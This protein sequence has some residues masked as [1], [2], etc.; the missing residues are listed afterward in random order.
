MWLWRDSVGNS[1]P[2]YCFYKFL[3]ALG[4]FLMNR[5]FVGTLVVASLLAT[6]AMAA[7]LPVKA[8]YTKAP[9]IPVYNWTGFY[10]GVNVGGSWG[11]ES[12]DGY[13]TGSSS[14]QRYTSI[15]GV[16]VGAPVVTALPTLPITGRSNVNGVLGGGQAGYNW[17]WQS[18]VLGVEA[19]FQ[20]TDEHSTSALCTVSGCPTGTTLYSTEYKLDWFGTARG[21]AGFLVMPQLLLY[22]TGGLAYGH[23]SADGPGLAD[24]GNTRAGWTAGAGAEWAFASNWS[25]KAEYLYMDLGNVGSGAFATTNSTTAL[26]VPVR[27]NTVTTV[28]T[29]GAFN[30]RFTDNILRVGINYKFGGPVV[31]RY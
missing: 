29:N 6:S 30:T 31:A 4:V 20:G 14:A 25:L 15:T 13:V 2:V 28:T 8:P 27:F 24:W 11:R 10:I 7:D 3:F 1:E 16:A 26:G 22:A 21:R 12:D 9:P 18:L 19:D 17:Q 5:N 23:L